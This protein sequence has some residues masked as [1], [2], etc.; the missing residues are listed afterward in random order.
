MLGENQNDPAKLTDLADARANETQQV[1][2]DM[3]LRVDAAL[4][5]ISRDREMIAT[6]FNV[7]PSDISADPVGELRGDIN[8][9][10][11]CT[12]YQDQIVAIAQRLR[13]AYP[14]NWG[15]SGP[16]AKADLER[17]ISAIFD[18]VDDRTDRMFA[19]EVKA[20]FESYV[21]EVET[22]YVDQ[23]RQ[24]ESR[25]RFTS[26]TVS[27]LGNS[28]TQD[29][30]AYFQRAFERYERYESA[31]SSSARVALARME[32]AKK[33][34]L[35]LWIPALALL[36]MLAYIAFLAME[37]HQRGIGRLAEGEGEDE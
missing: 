36:G 22:Y 9:P 17:D 4:D 19:R 3:N 23:R 2:A 8:F 27:I 10:G 30:R 35:L 7:S 1:C 34:L 13:A 18:E 28:I 24:L 26:E 37:R 20:G 21:K 32:R 6:T 12:V 25:N 29:C 5:S 15:L 16:D 33:A 11:E 31:L 14:V